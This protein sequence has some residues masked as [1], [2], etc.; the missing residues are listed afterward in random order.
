MTELTKASRKLRQ[1]NPRKWLC[2]FATSLTSVVALTFCVAWL[3]HVWTWWSLVSAFWAAIALGL[4][5]AFVKEQ[6]DS[7]L[8]ETVG[9]DLLKGNAAQLAELGEQ[10]RQARKEIKEEQS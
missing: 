9:D 8:P 7:L 3:L 2:I 6:L 5:A 4:C 10:M 1:L